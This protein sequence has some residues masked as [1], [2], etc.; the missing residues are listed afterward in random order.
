ML[1]EM[2]QFLHTC[3]CPPCLYGPSSVTAQWCWNRSRLSLNRS[4]KLGAENSP[5][6]LCSEAFRVHL[7]GTKLLKNSQHHNPPPPNFTLG[8]ALE[9]RRLV[10][11]QCVTS[12]L[13]RRM[14][15]NPHKHTPKP[16]G[17]PSQKSW[18]S[19]SS[20]QWK[21]QMDNEWDVV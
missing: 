20:K 21:N 10:H 19:Y 15:Q 3:P 1:D 9:S 8:T 14:F 2:I 13:C 5:K 11:H 12:Q 7:T 18:S 17:Q 16:C 4:A 6:S